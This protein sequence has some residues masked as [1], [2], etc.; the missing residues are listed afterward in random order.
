MPPPDRA[1]AAL[2]FAL[3]YPDLSAARGGAEAASHHAG[4]LKVGLQLFIREGPPAVRLG[5]SLGCDVFLDLKLHDIPAT[6]EHAVGSASQLGV[7]YLTLHAAG[8]PAMVEA[9][10][11]R[12]DSEGAGLKVLAVTVL[13][14]MDGDDLAATG[15]LSP[16]SEQVERLASLALSSG[17]HG[18]VCS[19]QEV[20]AL[21]DRHGDGPILVTPGIRPQ[22]GDVGDQKRVGTPTSAIQDGSSLL[23]VGRPIRDARE[24]EAAA[25]AIVDEIRT[26]QG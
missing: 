3:D 25:K 18:L 26:A 8:G 21:R 11:K 15:V 20:R 4:V 7:R 10:R 2:A 9:A 16:P 17:A 12:A 13:T 24:P 19:T 5:E 22:G 23:V 14:S 6:V 1:R